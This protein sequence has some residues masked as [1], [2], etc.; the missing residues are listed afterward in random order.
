M[1]TALA[2][3]AVLAITVL[4]TRADEETYSGIAKVEG[5]GT[6]AFPVGKWS[7]ETRVLRTLPEALEKPDYFVFKK[8]DEPMGRLTFLRYNPMIAPKDA[9]ACE[10]TVQGFSRLS[11]AKD[12]QKMDGEMGMRQI[13]GT[14]ANVKSNVEWQTTASW[15]RIPPAPKPPWLYYAG[16]Y[17]AGQWAIGVIR[18]STV[19]TDP[20]TLENVFSMSL[21]SKRLPE[22][23]HLIPP[24]LA[25][26]WQPA[27]EDLRKT[28]ILHLTEDGNCEIA[29][30]SSLDVLSF[31]IEGFYV[32]SDHMLVLGRDRFRY[33]GKT[34]MLVPGKPS[35]RTGANVYK[36][37]KP[38]EFLVHGSALTP[39]MINE[40]NTLKYEDMDMR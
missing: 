7:L 13:L 18:A 27:K 3:M 29:T 2:C 31:G 33:D 17:S 23:M 5:L 35:L 9:G 39:R 1:K 15:L 32:A 36:K 28:D 24:E 14:P 25:G 20:R 40:G 8:L 22:G 11:F 16:L 34:L 4:G 10:E 38:V 37:S 12:G 6:I 26:D 19:V 21:F 30:G